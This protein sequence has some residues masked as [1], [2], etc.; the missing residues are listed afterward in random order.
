MKK[1]QLLVGSY[2]HLPPGSSETV[3][4][5]TYQ[6]SYRPFLS[7]LYRFPELQATL[8]YSGSLLVWLE[9]RHPEFI[10]LLAEMASRKQVE[11]VGG[12]YFEP[13]LAWVPGPDRIGQVEALTVLIR[14]SFGRRPRGCWLAEYAWEPSV[15]S[16]LKTSGMDYTFLLD[17]AF[18]A[19]GLSGEIFDGPVTTEDQGRDIVV[20]PIHDCV[21]SFATVGGYAESLQSLRS[22]QPDASF[23]GLMLP[24]ERAEELWLAS[25]LESPDVYFERSFSAL[26]HLAPEVETVLPGRYLKSTGQLERAYF[27]SSASDRFLDAGASHALLAELQAI[28]K[29]LGGG[30]NGYP[31]PGGIRQAL[32]RTEEASLLYARMQYVHLLVSQL[33]GDKARK[34]TAQEELWSSQCAE[35]YWTAPSGGIADPAIRGAA[36]AS[37][38]EAEQITRQKGSFRPGIIQADIDS[39]R[40]KETLFQGQSYNAYVHARGGVL[41]ELDHFKSRRN[42]ASGYGGTA[43]EK[44]SLRR[45]CFVDSLPASPVSTEA[46]ASGLLDPDANLA[47][48][49][50]SILE[51]KRPNHEAGFLLEA[52][53]SGRSGGQAFSLEKTY[54]FKKSQLG[55]RYLFRNLSE[56]PIDRTFLSAFHFVPSYVPD[57]HALTVLAR[58]A[59]G[60]ERE[61]AV[62]AKE[63]QAYQNAL[64]ATLAGP[65]LADPLT[66]ASDKPCR[67]IIAPYKDRSDGEARWQGLAV[68]LEWRLRLAPG[69]EWKALVSLS[70]RDDKA[71]EGAAR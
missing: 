35:A 25:G 63:S 69:A 65:D 29:R 60:V 14:K 10:M 71:Q 30:A 18:Q 38:L 64:K 58:E 16:S 66:L 48:F 70:F 42:L 27:P 44:G 56:E 20:F 51:P 59:D 26:A 40:V 11:L 43:T 37:L 33:R 49:W 47:A 54:V 32:I 4:E 62:G 53:L 31:R 45:R 67:I 3:L 17:R 7:V 50:Y 36:Y 34:K 52:A 23:L 8:H 57:G 61:L 6:K 28:R 19:A 9:R 24:G 1:I 41:F 21:A 22:K 68:A 15:A 46:L 5:S 12:A 39:D 13:I 2:N 55:V